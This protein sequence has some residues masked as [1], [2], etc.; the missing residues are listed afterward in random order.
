MTGKRN[1]ATLM[2]LNRMA[3]SA[4]RFEIVER[5]VSFIFRQSG[6]LPVLMVDGQILVVSTANALI[7]VARKCR[8][9]ISAKV[10]F[11]L[12]V[13]AILRQLILVGHP[14]GFRLY[15][16]CF[17]PTGFAPF[18]RGCRVS[19]RRP[20]ATGEDGTYGNSPG[21][22]AVSAQSRDVIGL[23]VCFP[24]WIAAQLGG[25]RRDD[26]NATIGAGNG[27]IWHG[28]ILPFHTELAT[29]A[30]AA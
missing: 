15:S 4:K 19:E 26:G 17:I 21:L 5:V 6:A 10:A 13:P 30:A 7:A 23:P 11:I 2:M 12:G 3:G 25:G 20:A 8:L 14:P 9:S 16:P 27:A 24:A 29:L 28:R 22:R 1:I 18:F